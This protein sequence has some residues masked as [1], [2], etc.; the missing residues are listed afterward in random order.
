[1]IRRT[2]W[3][4]L[5]LLAISLIA[6]WYVQRSKSKA[7]ANVTPTTQ[8]VSLLTIDEASI[9]DLRVV[10]SSG[11]A[12]ELGRDTAGVWAV[13][14]P[15][16]GPTDIAKAESAVSQLTGMSMTTTLNPVTDLGAFGLNKA[17]YTITVSMK[18]GQRHVILVGDVTPLGDGYYVQVDGKNPQVVNKYSL[19]SFLGIL[20]KPPFQDT[21]TPVVST[22]PTPT[23]EGNT[24][25]TPSPPPE[26]SSTPT[27]GEAGTVTPTP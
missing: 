3:V 19:D 4:L 23:P 8:V 14:E 1:M 12:V 6:F 20:S 11:K 22:T 7:S 10:D 5:A 13:K 17:V 2:T 9:T 26:T 18:D 15:L 25:G 27:P 16:G 24:T 21:P